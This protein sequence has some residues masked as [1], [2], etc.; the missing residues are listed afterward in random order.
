MDGAAGER[1]HDR[2]E[3][4]CAGRRDKRECLCARL[5]DKKDGMEKITE[6]SGYAK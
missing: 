1:G 2:E 4:N 5:D 6:R 3:E